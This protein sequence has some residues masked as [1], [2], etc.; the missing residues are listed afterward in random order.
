MLKVAVRLQPFILMKLKLTLSLALLASTSLLAGNVNNVTSQSPPKMKPFSVTSPTKSVS[1]YAA[2]AFTPDG[3]S[4][5]QIRAAYG[6]TVTNTTAAG[7]TIALIVAYGSPTLLS[8][9]NVYSAQFGLPQMTTSTLQIVTMPGGPAGGSPFNDS[10]AFETS[11]DTELAH[12]IAPGATIMVVVAPSDSFPD[13]VSAVD[14]A[15]AHGAKNISMSW[16][17]SEWP[18]ET[19]YDSHFNKPGVNFFA[20]SGD[21]GSGVNYPAAS[22]YVIGV[23]GTTLVLNPANN[24]VA[25]EVGWS[26]SSGGVSMYE[27][28][29]AYQAAWLNQ[30]AHR[31]VPD[32]S[33][34][35]SSSTPYAVY[36][37]H[38]T[39][40]HAYGTS[41]A[42]PQWAALVAGGKNL[43]TK[44]FTYGSTLIYDLATLN[45]S[46]YFRD[47][48]SGSNGGYTAGVKYDYVTGLGS[49][50]AAF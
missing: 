46:M 50:P 15:V 8:D 47:M 29:P 40:I 18:G 10:W 39:W 43:R 4:P 42:A 41:C 6:L 23:G 36:G 30:K 11:L 22:P 25:S 27:P 48:T 20:A 49:L 26:G 31:G 38:H 44:N 19:A 28:C 37:A 7:Q 12:A 3:Y 1:P 33:Y 16:G 35:A 45:Y 34:N 2:T 32:V 9:V 21:S 14:Y 24:T 17:F 13:L 5:A